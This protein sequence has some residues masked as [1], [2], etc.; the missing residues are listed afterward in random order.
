MYSHHYLW[1]GIVTN[2]GFSKLTNCCSHFPM[3]LLTVLTS[4]AGCIGNNGKLA[5]Q[6]RD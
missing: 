4:E 5:T 1:E 6:S 2:Q 3:I